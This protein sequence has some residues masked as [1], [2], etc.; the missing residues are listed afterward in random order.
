M[1]RRIETTFSIK[2]HN[3][4]NRSALSN[5]KFACFLGIEVFL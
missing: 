1:T 4:F 2:H 5:Q 3:Y